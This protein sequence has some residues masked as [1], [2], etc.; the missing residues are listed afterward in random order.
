MGIENL[1]DNVKQLRE[2]VHGYGDPEAQEEL[3]N[4]LLKEVEE[5]LPVA[6]DQV[7]VSVPPCAAL[8]SSP[9]TKEPVSLPILSSRPASSSMGEE[10]KK[11]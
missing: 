9:L 7:P 3:D 10:N 4:M 5:T 1:S 8:V 11:M 6:M 2:E